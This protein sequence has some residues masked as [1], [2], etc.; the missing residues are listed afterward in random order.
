MAQTLL[1]FTCMYS[2]HT[3][4]SCDVLLVGVNAGYIHSAFA[5]R[6]LLVNLGRLRP[7]ARIIE[8]DSRDT[9]P[10]QFVER[11]LLLRPSVIGFSVY[12][13]NVTFIAATLRLLRLVAPEVALLLGGP[14]FAPQVP[15]SP[16]HD[17]A[18][19][20]VCGEAEGIIE[21][22]CQRLL[23]GERR[24]GTLCPPLPDLAAIK[25]PYPLYSA[26]DLAHRVVYAE[27]TRGCPFACTYCTSSESGGIRRFDLA[28]LLPQLH[29]LLQRGASGFKFL[30]R[31]FNHGGDHALTVLDFLLAHWRE[32][33]TL[34]FE[35]TPGK[36][37]PAWRERLLRFPPQGLH[38]EVGIQ[39]W[40]AT[41]AARIRRPFDSE[42]VTESLR[43]LID[44]ARAD[45]H[46]DLIVGLPGEDSASFAAGFDRLVRLKPAELQVGILKLLPGTALAD[47]VAEFDLRFAPDPPYEI[48]STSVIPFM[49]M[50]RL[51]RFARAWDLLY[52]R[53]RF[54]QTAALLCNPAES[55]FARVM[56]ISDWLQDNYGRLHA[57]APKQ[58]A[59]AIEATSPPAALPAIRR[60]LE[61]DFRQ[62]RR[63]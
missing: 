36:I 58:I 21:A 32:G 42:I 4:D 15:H 60:C 52:N 55:P 61:A 45:V 20:V 18:D 53:Q 33:L 35:F 6:C 1:Q 44:E 29:D 50:R 38:L 41:V 57:L 9:T 23:A 46:A 54:D 48:L 17:L 5:P 49:E 16:L 12:V 30:D 34:H 26:D 62:H 14:Q 39:T 10:E 40:D 19:A 13:W 2:S 51:T 7:R 63:E 8:T 22:V 3:D 24:L 11:L 31:S 25:L 56:E 59:K 47:D 28:T 43:F 37:S 27:T